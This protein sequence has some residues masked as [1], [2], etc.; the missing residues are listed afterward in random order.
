MIQIYAQIHKQNLHNMPIA[1]SKIIISPVLPGDFLTIARLEAAAFADDDFSA[2]AFGTQRSSD[3]ALASRAASFGAEPKPGE[4][5][6]NMKAVALGFGGEEIVGFASW[7]FRIGRRGTD[8]DMKRAEE[9][10]AG[11]EKEKEGEK[12]TLGTGVN[13]KF[14]E[15]SI[16]KGDE[17]MERSTEGRDYA[18]KWWCFILFL[19]I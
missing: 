19:R 4:S 13:M 9:T 16:L 2:V 10:K 17:H 6:R 14:F 7:T 5:I 12:N 1:D 11:D 15:D 8:G 3:E 18:S